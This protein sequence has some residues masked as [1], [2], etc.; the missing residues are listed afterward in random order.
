MSIVECSA[1]VQK[2]EDM[3]PRSIDSFDTFISSN[4]SNVYTYS[5]ICKLNTV[6]KN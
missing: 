3:R 2:R 4:L 6:D 1:Q 5:I